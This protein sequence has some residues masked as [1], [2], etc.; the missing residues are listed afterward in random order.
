M[1]TETLEDGFERGDLW[2]RIALKM[3]RFQSGR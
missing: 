2:E 1:K 3:H